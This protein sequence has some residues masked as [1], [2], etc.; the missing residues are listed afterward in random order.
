MKVHAARA[1]LWLVSILLGL[2][3]FAPDWAAADGGRRPF[4]RIV[5]FGDSLSD[6]G[7]V[8]ALTGC[9]LS[10]D[11]YAT[12]LDELLVPTCPYAKGG[13]HFSNGPTWVED[14]G[15]S[16][17]LGGNVRPAFGSSGLN[18]TNYAVGGA[19][20]RADGAFHLATQIGAFFGDFPRGVSGEA[21]YVVQFGGN[22]VRDGLLVAQAAGGG[23]GGV[24]AAVQQVFGP[25]L[26]SVADAIFLLWRDAGAKNILVW[27]VPNLGRAPAITRLDASLQQDPT[28]VP[29]SVIAGATTLASIYNNGL[30]GTTFTGLA[31]VLNGLSSSLPGIH[32]MSFDTFGTLEKVAGKPQKFG[33]QNVTDACIGLTPPFQCSNPDRY[34]FWDGIH[35]TRAGHAIVAIEVG[36]TLIVD[37]LA[38]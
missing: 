25:A 2:V 27:N 9:S 37:L 19:R 24:Q 38:H 4:D 17:G 21:L 8:F 28:Y 15:R 1:K 7:N 18:A 16:I 13:N 6:P 36:K 10:P 12:G 34:L 35:P 5:V 29:G 3:A 33:L 26:T 32:I 14:L 20:A 22:D 30:P 11:E 23:P 31:G